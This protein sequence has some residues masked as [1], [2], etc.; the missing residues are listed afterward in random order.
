MAP[1]DKTTLPVGVVEMIVSTPLIKAVTPVA[2]SPSRSTLTTRTPLWRRK[3]L[4]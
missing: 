3:L 2:V 1:A 4:R